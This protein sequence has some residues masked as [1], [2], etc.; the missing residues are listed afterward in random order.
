MKLSFHFYCTQCFAYVQSFEHL[1]EDNVLCPN[2]NR[3]CI[4]KNLCNGNFFVTTD[5]K[6]QV[7]VL[8]ERKDIISPHLLYTTSRQKASEEAIEDMMAH[9]IEICWPMM[10]Y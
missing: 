10:T 6:S 8:F 1:V 5:L 3:P 2:C 7:K 4:V 9:F